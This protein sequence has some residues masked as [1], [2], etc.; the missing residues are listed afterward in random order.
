MRR[1]AATLALA[2]SVA[3]SGLAM[4][5]RGQSAGPPAAV[6][7]PAWRA[8]VGDWESVEPAQAGSG[9]S[10]FRLEL[11]GRAIIRRNRAEIATGA[12]RTATP[13]EDMMVIY[14][15][16]AGNAARALYVDNEDHVVQYAASWSPDGKVLTFVSDAIPGAPRF[17]L[18]YEFQSASEVAIRFEMA[19]PDSPDAFK[20][21]VTGK[22]RRT[23]TAPGR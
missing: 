17:R 5:Q 21:Y 8:L 2:V 15:T 22:A 4:T 1:S 9:A 6:F 18:I 13:H 14:P 11:D 10:S 12:A 16:G 19:A 20:P 23:A 7:G 3:A